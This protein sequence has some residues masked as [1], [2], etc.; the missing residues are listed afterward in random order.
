[1]SIPR[2]S[3]RLI[4]PD[5]EET[6]CKSVKEILARFEPGDHVLAYWCGEWRRFHFA[7]PQTP[8]EG[9][10]AGLSKQQTA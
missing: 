10:H 3:Y 1:M 7:Y 2:S 9:R 4:H 8:G 5:G 6:E